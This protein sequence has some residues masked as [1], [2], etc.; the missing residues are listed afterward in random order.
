MDFSSR[1]VKISLSTEELFKEAGFIGNV[2]Q[3][4]CCNVKNLQYI[5]DENKGE[6]VRERTSKEKGFNINTFLLCLLIF[7]LLFIVIANMMFHLKKLLVDRRCYRTSRIESA[8]VIFKTMNTEEMHPDI[9]MSSRGNTMNQSLLKQS[10]IT[11]RLPPHGEELLFEEL[12]SRL[13]R[14]SI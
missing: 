12:K 14:Q 10:T 1:Q 8:E 9:L 5:L 6:C 4:S 3:G 13:T 11:I 2:K 7:L